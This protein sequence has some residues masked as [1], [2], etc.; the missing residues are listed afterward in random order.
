MIR[1]GNQNNT[2]SEQNQITRWT[3]IVN[4]WTNAAR[5]TDCIIIGDLN[6]DMFKWDKPDQIQVGMFEL[7]K[8]E[9]LT[10]GFVQLVKG[11]TR[12]WPGK[13]DSLIDHLW[14]NRPDRIS[15][16]ANKV[17]SQGDHNLIL[18]EIR[19]KKSPVIQQ[20]FTVRNMKKKKFSE[21]LL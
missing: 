10:L 1:Q 11:M 2:M 3:R 9:I 13:K 17:R 16:L 14:T 19:I 12:A 5:N 8:S 7:L 4:Q 6:L 21:G 18:A 15:H 20:E